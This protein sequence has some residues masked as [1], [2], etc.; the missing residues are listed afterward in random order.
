M[1]V[2]WGAG[3]R[4]R[5]LGRHPACALWVV[6]HQERLWVVLVCEWHCT[7]VPFALVEVLVGLF[8]T[9]SSSESSFDVCFAGGGLG[10]GLAGEAIAGVSL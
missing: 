6:C 3:S 10:G 9:K 5:R 2:W 7:F 1:E 8:E 4:D